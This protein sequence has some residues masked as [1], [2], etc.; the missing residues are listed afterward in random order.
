[1]VDRPA[2]QLNR[3]R[4]LPTAL[5]IAVGLSACTSSA[6]PT[7]RSPG[8]ATA[9]AAGS[10]EPSSAISPVNTAF[11]SPSPSLATLRMPN[12]PPS[13]SVAAG[14]STPSLLEP[15]SCTS[16]Q[17]SVDV[18]DAGAAMQVTYALIVVSNTA[19]QSCA[20]SGVL[21]VQLLA[22]GTALGTASSSP[23][24]NVVVAGGQ[25]VAAQL[26]DKSSCNAALST[27]IKVVLG[28]QISATVPFVLRG[29]SLSTGAFNPYNV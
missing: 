15:L 22:S 12:T 7:F 4:L 13:P 10:G 28:K 6:S 25:S 2:H 29:C 27:D 19:A 5:L 20:L 17:L 23:V 24:S 9:S 14:E 1:M 26:Q 8:V 16:A 21:A 11:G 18:R 3:Y